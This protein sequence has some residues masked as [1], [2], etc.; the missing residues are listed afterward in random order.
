VVDLSIEPDWDSLA[1]MVEEQRFELHYCYIVD[2]IAVG[3]S[4]S[5]T[6]SNDRTSSYLLEGFVGCN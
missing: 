4:W 3:D 1:V 6:A 5:W 2:Y